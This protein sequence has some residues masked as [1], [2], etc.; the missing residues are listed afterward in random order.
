MSLKNAI[1]VVAASALITCS[2]ASFAH[3]SLE[4]RLAQGGTDLRAVLVVGHGCAGSP[5][6]AV[7]V[8]IPAGFS[9]TAPQTKSG[10]S[11]AVE[12]NSLAQP[13]SGKAKTVSDEVTRVTWTATGKEFSVPDGKREKFELTGKLAATAGPLWFKVMQTCETGSNNWAQ[14]PGQGISVAALKLPA[15]LLE[16]TAG[17]VVA[18]P[19]QVSG[20]WV[21]STVGGQK[22]TGAFMQLKAARP[23]RLVGVT[24]PVAAVS[25]V[26][27]MKME[28][29]VM[30]MRQVN[31]LDLP[32][33]VA[34]ELK[35]GGY[36]LMLM[37]LKQ[38][39]LPGSTV[40]LTLRFQDAK[41]VESQLNVN[42]TASTSAPGVGGKSMGKADADQPHKH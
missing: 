30:K 29:D 27:E 40:P 21:R 11:V 28:G 24:S 6:T 33:G 15:A 1:K 7:S 39:V 23:M 22:G 41:G 8:Q 32:A 2:A 9:G 13:A 5:T 37:D 20:A 14:I 12:R 17:P 3:V 18:N 4:T 42:L 19:V 16:V 36:H 38:P 26:H 31:A 34:V 35:P 25:E 10:W